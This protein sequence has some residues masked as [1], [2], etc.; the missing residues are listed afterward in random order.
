MAN[1]LQVGYPEVP[2]SITN[3]NVKRQD[4]LDLDGPMSFLT[5]I[6]I[7]NVSFEPDSLQ[8]Y[9]NH[10][11]KDWNSQSIAKV[12]SDN[13]LIVNEYRNFI[14]EVSINYTTPDEKEFLAKIDYNDP[15]DLDIILGFYG[16]KL[17][18]LTQFYN[19]KR[20]N[21]KFE[22]TKSKLRGSKIELEKQISELVLSYLKSYDEGSIHYN[23]DQIKSKLEIEVLELYN[24]SPNYFNQTPNEQ[25]YDDKDLDYGLDIFFK[26]NETL[27]ADLF[28]DMSEELKSIKELPE[29]FDT[30]RE[31]T[32]KTLAFPF[33]YI[34]TGSTVTDILSGK[35]F[36][37]IDT[38][39]N[40]LNPTYPTTA[41]TEREEYLETPQKRGFFRPTNTTIVLIDGINSSFKINFDNLQ[42]NSFYLFPDPTITGINGDVLTF[43]V[44]DSFLKKNFSSGQANNHPLSYPYDT[45][46]YGY[47]SKIEPS[48]KKYLDDIFDIGWVKDSKRDIYGNLYGLFVNDGRFKSTITTSTIPAITSFIFNGYEFFDH[49]YNEGFSFNWATS[50]YT[51]YTELRRSGLTLSSGNFNTFIPDLKLN[52]GT[53][54][55]NKALAEHSEAG[56]ATTYQILE[57]AYIMNGDTLLS[58]LS[59]SDLSAYEFSTDGFYYTDLYE[60]G[61]TTVNPLKRA[62]RDNLYPSSTGN[63]LSLGNQLTAF[64]VVDGGRFEIPFP[65]LD[66]GYGYDSYPYDGTVYKPTTLSQLSSIPLDGLLMVRNTYTKEILPI[67]DAMPFLT[68]KYSNDVLTDIETQVVRYEI[69]SDVLS[70][71]SPSHLIIHKIKFENGSFVDPYCPPFTISHSLSNFDKISNRVRVNYDIYF[72]K[73]EEPDT[74]KIYPKI[75]KYNIIT[76]KSSLVYPLPSD[77]Y[78]YLNLVT[79]GKKFIS[80]E[81][82]LLTY[83]ALTNTFNISIFMKDNNNFGDVYSYTFYLNPNVV[84]EDPII[85]P[86]DT[87]NHTNIFGTSV[88][89]AYLSSFMTATN[90]GELIL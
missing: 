48:W 7:I 49:I 34:Q 84:F 80:S 27:M 5:F 21:L 16:R 20:H 77:S 53:F 44:D 42:P 47:V 71:E 19:S 50:D 24:T 85:V 51:T 72:C 3:P 33:Y 79:N 60:S 73:F 14:K 45:K 64:T 35:L 86:L 55:N 40:F 30:K 18:E 76:N 62:L 90:N 52:Y 68:S 56:L 4:A 43:V 31:L 63:F 9:Y 39:S 38:A 69:T 41:S 2:R 25:V 61:I 22:I 57:N 81:A 70:I 58:D 89:T 1:T 6:K 74:T 59:S 29:L 36:D 32:K 83:S 54:A 87:Y 78:N 26:D 65:E 10:Y 88:V 8:N 23:Y 66:Y 28:S 67:I 75:Y 37:N 13:V 17:R 46:Y 82:P 12:D 11:L 15:L